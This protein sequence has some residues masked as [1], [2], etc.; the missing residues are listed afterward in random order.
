MSNNSSFISQ[1]CCVLSTCIT[2]VAALSP[3]SM[4]PHPR[5]LSFSSQLAAGAPIAKVPSPTFFCLYLSCI[6]HLHH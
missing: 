5:S 4:S 3:T 1:A 2:R 6:N